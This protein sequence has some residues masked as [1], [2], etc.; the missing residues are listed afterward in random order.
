MEDKTTPGF[1]PMRESVRAGETT[2]ISA[3][4][5]GDGDAYQELCRRHSRQVFRTVM[6]ILHN[7]EDAEDVVQESLIK[8]F[9]NLPFFKQTSTFSTWLNRIGINFALMQLR[10]R[11]SGINRLLTFPIESE[12]SF[13]MDVATDSPSPED[14]VSAAEQHHALLHAISVLPASLRGII[15]SRFHQEA[16]I[17]EI[18]TAIGL[19][20]PAVKSRLHRA[21]SRLRQ[22]M[23]K[24]NGVAQETQM[25]FKP[26]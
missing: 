17:R 5:Q 6:R 10:R 24:R 20:E 15:G 12:E 18:A 8:A 13:L 2:L 19:S 7:T 14:L 16:S 21:R 4:L 1:L 3:A 9:I 23:A 26:D 25:K 11:R 22:T